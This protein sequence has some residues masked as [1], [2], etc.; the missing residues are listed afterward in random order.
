[1][2]IIDLFDDSDYEDDPE[3]KESANEA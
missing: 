1:M 2:K 3:D